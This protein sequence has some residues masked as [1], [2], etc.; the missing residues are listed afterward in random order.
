MSKRFLHE[1]REKLEYYRDSVRRHYQDVRTGDSVP[2]DLPRNLVVGQRVIARHPKEKELCKG[3]ILTV[4]LKKF[5][6]QFDRPEM[7]VELVA[8]C[9]HFI[10]FWDVLA[11]LFMSVHLLVNRIL[12]VC[13]SMVWRIYQT[14]Q[15]KRAS[16]LMSETEI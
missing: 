1:E 9:L 14:H 8:V 6:V 3:S 16:K 5:R 11:R 15:F 12:I 4:D 10:E 2:P 7:G 13:Q